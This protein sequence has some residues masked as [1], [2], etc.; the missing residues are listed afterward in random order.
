MSSPELLHKI[1]LKKTTFSELP[2]KLLS[3]VKDELEEKLTN[4]NEIHEYMDTFLRKL[5]SC[6][7]AWEKESELGQW[8]CEHFTLSKN[9]KKRH[10]S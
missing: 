6:F 5:S 8:I 9:G 1:R 4:R 3:K 7:K 10:F 2:E